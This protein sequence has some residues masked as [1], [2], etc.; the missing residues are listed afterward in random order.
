[1]AGDDD[2][3]YLLENRQLLLVHVEPFPAMDSSL[4]EKMVMKTVIVKVQ[5]AIEIVRDHYMIYGIPLG[6]ERDLLVEYMSQNCACV[7][8]V[9][10]IALTESDLVR[11]CDKTSMKS[12]IFLGV[13]FV[14]LFILVAFTVKHLLDFAEALNRQ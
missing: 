11:K 10:G 14:I 12:R 6:S 13:Y 5:D 4:E 3:D 2:I 1:M 8:H 9:N 7:F